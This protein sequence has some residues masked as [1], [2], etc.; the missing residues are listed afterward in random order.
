MG[1][2]LNATL[3]LGEAMITLTHSCGFGPPKPPFPGNKM[4]ETKELQGRVD[5]VLK[6]RVEEGWR[7]PARYSQLPAS[8]RVSGSY[9]VTRMCFV[10]LDSFKQLG[11]NK[12]HGRFW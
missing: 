4:V 12:A 9:R 10:S 5:I 6:G 11:E 2:V 8:R 1:L 3:V 7:G